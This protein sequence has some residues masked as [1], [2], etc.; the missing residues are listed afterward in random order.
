MYCEEQVHCVRS[1]CLDGL[2]GVGQTEFSASNIWWFW[3][4]TLKDKILL[5]W[6]ASM[7]GCVL[8]NAWQNAIKQIIL[9]SGK[10]LL[11]SGLAFKNCLSLQCA[12]SHQ[13]ILQPLTSYTSC[14]SFLL[15]I[16]WMLNL[17]SSVRQHSD[18]VLSFWIAGAIFKLRE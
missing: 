18:L 15:I 8:F 7:W 11:S 4:M 14:V 12:P 13:C 1:C 3:Q 10:L 2:T 17:F 5:L 16:L 6:I 9:N